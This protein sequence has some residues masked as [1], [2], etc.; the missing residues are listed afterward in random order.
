[1]LRKFFIVSF[2]FTFHFSV[3]Q[4]IQ[5]ATKLIEYSSQLSPYEYAASQVLDKPDVL[6]DAGDNPNAWLPNNPD[7]TEFIKVGFDYPT[8]PALFF[9][10]LLTMKMAKNTSSILLPLRL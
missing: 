5:W 2:F 6:P 7:K 10:F 1:M 9:R 3:G 8:I 4:N